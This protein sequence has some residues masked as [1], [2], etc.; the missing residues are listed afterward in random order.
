MICWPT[1]SATLL[2]RVR[3]GRMP[4]C[5]EHGASTWIAGGRLG[6]PVGPSL[7]VIERI[8]DAAA[9]LAVSGARAVGSVLFQ[10]TA[11]KAKESGRL[12]RAQV[13]WRQAGVRIAHLKNS[14]VLWSASEFGGAS[15]DTLAE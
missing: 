2:P 3:D 9:D 7:E 1:W 12:G 14:V 4:F 6:A 15:T 11:G 10:G 13:S 8:D 5:R